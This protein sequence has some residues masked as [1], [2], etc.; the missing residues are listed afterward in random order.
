MEQLCVA[1]CG[2]SLWQLFVYTS[3]MLEYRD[4]HRTHYRKHMRMYRAYNIHTQISF[5]MRTDTRLGWKHTQWTLCCTAYHRSS[6]KTRTKKTRVG[7]VSFCIVLQRLLHRCLIWF[8]FIYIVNRAKSKKR[9]KSNDARGFCM[10]AF[11]CA[12][13]CTCLSVCIR[14][15]LLFES[16]CCIDISNSIQFVDFCV[17]YVKKKIWKRLDCVW[18]THFVC[19]TVLVFFARFFGNRPHSQF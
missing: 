11:G 13:R 2:M 1:L 17:R 19:T 16:N 9:G 15:V 6:G 8:H 10:F 14:L 7:I 5:A 3:N 18:F 4:A 12:C